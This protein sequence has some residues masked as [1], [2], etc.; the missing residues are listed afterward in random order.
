MRI[1]KPQKIFKIYLEWLRLRG[2][3]DAIENVD[4]AAAFVDRVGDRFDVESTADKL[5][6]V[7]LY[8]R[9]IKTAKRA[10]VFTTKTDVDRANLRRVSAAKLR[11][12]T[13]AC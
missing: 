12:K 4:L 2:V 7:Q 6:A 3:R 1:E 10:R 13:A 5:A 9:P 11:Q 8:S